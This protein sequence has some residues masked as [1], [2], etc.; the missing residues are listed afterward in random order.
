MHSSAYDFV[1]RSP[2]GTP[3]GEGDVQPATLCALADIPGERVV[4]TPVLP[5]DATRLEGLASDPDFKNW[6]PWRRGGFHADNAAA[7]AGEYASASWAGGEPVWAI[8]VNGELAGVIDLRNRGDR[9]WEVGFWLHPEHRGKGLMTEANRLVARAA[10]EILGASRLLHFARVGNYPSLRVAQRLGF[11]LEG[12]RRKYV[13]GK[14]QWQ[15][16]SAILASDWLG[17]R[18]AVS[19]A[20]GSGLRASVLPPAG[21]IGAEELAERMASVLAEAWSAAREGG[22]DLEGALLRRVQRPLRS[23]GVRPR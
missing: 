12:V 16:Q 23:G 3:T 13:R 4:L 1:V 9:S 21:E 22:L 17:R 20:E 10:F 8:R 14:V 5:E 7:F 6:L 15:W 2:L 19:A 11:Q 18:G